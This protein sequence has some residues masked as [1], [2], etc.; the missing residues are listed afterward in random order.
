MLRTDPLIP[1]V[2]NIGGKTLLNRE[3]L[4]KYIVPHSAMQ[5]CSRKHLAM[6]DD[7]GGMLRLHLNILKDSPV[8]L[9]VQNDDII[10][11]RAI[12]LYNRF[13]NCI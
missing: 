10:L 6:Q 8:L 2:D 13:A 11:R 4:F 7:S 3:L 5:R 1:G 9:A 12:Q